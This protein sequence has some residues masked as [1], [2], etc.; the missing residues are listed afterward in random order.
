LTGLLL[1]TEL[2]AEQR[3]YAETVRASSD[4]LLTI[5]NDILDF[6][7]IEAGKLE[8]EHQPFDLRECL[9]SALDL[10][11]T[12]ATEKGVDLAYL[13]DDQ[14]PAGVYGDVTRLRQ[15]LVNLLSNAVKFTE[16]GE[17]VIAVEA[18]RTE[19]AEDGRTHEQDGHESAFYEL[20]FAVR[21][22]GIGISEEG[23]ARLFRSF[24]QVDTSTTRRYGGTGLGLAISK[25]LAELM[26]GTMWVDSQPGAGSTFHFTLLAQPAPARWRPYLETSQPY[27]AGKRLLIVDDNETNRS[28]L[29]LQTQSWGMLPYAYPSGKEALAQV[30]AGVLF[31][32]AILD[33]QMPD[34]DG[35]MLAEQIRRSRNAQVLPLVMLTSLGRR[36]IETRGVEFAAFLN[37]PIKPSQLYNALLSIFAEQAR[38]APALKPTEAKGVQFDA[39]LGQ[40]LPLRILL[41]EDNTVNQK[42]ALRLLERMGYRA[43]VVANGLEVLEALQRQRY[44]MILMDVQMQEMD[45]LEASR[46][47]HEGWPAEEHPRIVAMTANAMQG[48][49]EEC[50]AAGMDD[51]LTKPIQIK[52]LQEAVERVGLW[53]RVHRRL[54]SPLSP[55]KTAPL[56]LEAEEQAELDPALDPTVL[57][58]LRQFQGEGELDIVQELAEAFQFETP[59][60]LETLR[61]A[62]T[63]GQPE[64]LRRAAH[65]LK[66]SSN[67][68]GA[69]T[70]AALSTELETLGKNGTV[71]G[72]AELVTRL[73]QEYQ[74]VCRA[75]A[76]EIARA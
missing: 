37:K 69:L 61:Q 44:D 29:T 51:Y 72:A 32:V 59:P 45:G 55:V 9:E 17:V 15:V 14:V 76:T 68:L 73:E 16:Q 42:L 43:D 23:K 33:I 56:T 20:H 5:I 41:A 13:V 54:T 27:L 38:P 12:R 65:N 71:A 60:L 28:I 50:L 39:L 18:R 7:K 24:S 46:T 26:G 34:M 36:E 58:E 52:A 40:R 6:S 8:L 66:G 21:D 63:E 74:H 19:K 53:A 48:D 67:N 57:V 1:D 49:R 62:V 75:L 30:Q 47:I 70:M 3:E 11:A 4:A 2:T 31:D 64:Q 35:L 25:R 10:V 22:T